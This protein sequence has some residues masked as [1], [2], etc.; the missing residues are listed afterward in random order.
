MFTLLIRGLRPLARMRLGKV[1]VKTSD[2]DM[3]AP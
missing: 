1:V 3:E 2:E